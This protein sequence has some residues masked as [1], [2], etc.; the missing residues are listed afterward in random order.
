MRR[1]YTCSTHKPHF[2]LSLYTTICI[3]V[4]CSCY[5][6]ICRYASNIYF[7]LLLSYPFAIKIINNSLF[8]SFPY[9]FNLYYFIQDSDIMLSLSYLEPPAP[10]LLILNYIFFHCS[11][12]CHKTKISTFSVNYKSCAKEQI[13]KEKIIAPFFEIYTIPFMAND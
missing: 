9:Y 4:L 7:Y 6:L 1:H 3:S 13:A 5:S 11:K 12:C 10:A 2:L 8:F